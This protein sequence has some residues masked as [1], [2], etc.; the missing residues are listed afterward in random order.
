[1]VA[2]PDKVK[3]GT[4]TKIGWVTG[5]IES[6]VISSPTQS[7]FSADN[8]NNA[9]P[10]GFAQTPQL[11]QNT[12]FVLNCTTKAGGVRSASTTVVVID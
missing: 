12:Q 7:A 8:E 9:K 4:A 5:G 2:H 10:A 11:T 6:C 1:M 3:K